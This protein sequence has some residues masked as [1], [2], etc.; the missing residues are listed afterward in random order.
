MCLLLELTNSRLHIPTDGTII[1]T[2][3]HGQIKDRWEIIIFPACPK[4][5][6]SSKSKVPCIVWYYDISDLVP[7]YKIGI[8][9]YSLWRYM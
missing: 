2:L 6:M 1:V 3:G 8:I 9:L 5:N 7:V 4:S